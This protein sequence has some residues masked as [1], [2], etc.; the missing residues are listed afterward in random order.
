MQIDIPVFI[1]SHSFNL[2]KQ[3]GRFEMKYEGLRTTVN[4]THR[5][6]RNDVMG[7]AMITKVTT[8]TTAMASKI[9]LKSSS[10]IT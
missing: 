5:K 4:T 3:Y 1:F 8:K 2:A 9:F 6:T 7:L 10:A